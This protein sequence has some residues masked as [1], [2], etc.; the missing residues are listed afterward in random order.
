MRNYLTKY[1]TA[2]LL[3]FVLTQPALAGSST[4][5]VTPGSGATYDVITDGSGNFVGMQGICD[6]SAAAYCATVTSGHLLA[7]QTSIASG[8]VASGAYASGA[9]ASGSIAAGAMVDL[10]TMRGTVGAG[11]APADALIGGAVYNSTPIT[12]SNTQS[13]AL[14]S[15]ANGF[16]KVNVAGGSLAVTGTFYQT[17]QPV[18]IASAQVASGAIAS[19]A[20]ASGSVSSGAFAS[21]SLAAGSMVDL[22]TMR[23][24]IGGTS[25]SPADVL[26]AGCQY[27]A[28][29]PTYTTSDSGAVQC[30]TNGYQIVSVANSSIAVTGTFY[31]ATQPVSIASAQ[32]ASGAYAS[33]SIASGA[34]A[35]GA[36]AS[37]AIVSG[38]D[39]TEGTTADTTVYAGSGGCT[40]VACLKGIYAGVNGSVPAGSALIGS[41]QQY[42]GSGVVSA[43]NGGYTNLLQGNAVIAT[44]NPIFA[45]LTAG[46]AIAGKFGIDQTTPG[47]TNAVQANVASGGIASG[48]Y[49]SGAFA[50]GAAASGSWAD[51]SV[52]TLGAKADAKSTATDTTA[53]TA[54]Q[55]FKEISYMAQNPAGV[56]ATGVSVPANAALGGCV[57]SNA[58]QTAVT[59]GQLTGVEC[60][61]NGKTITLPYAVKE[62]ASRGANSSTSTGTTITLLPASGTSGVY[63]YLTDLECGNTSATNV[64]VTLNDSASSVFMVPATYGGNNKSF[65]IP[66]KGPNNGALTATL[67]TNASTIYCN[68]QGY[69]GQ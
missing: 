43:T 61:L 36:I 52:V 23:A 57:G 29:A 22:L 15:D 60:G 37:G 50:S 33:G 56:G 21:G 51:G 26:V 31:Q 25:S 47:T 13:A 16:L 2:F 6:Q 24:P 65:E 32:V 49:A 41:I 3:G 10:L 68:G 20:Y 54:M 7:T 34:F 67:S 19:G 11:T 8:G 12:V 40:V 64:Y 42:I 55:V 58:D 9:L 62:N 28:S 69:N 48:A 44:G 5:S 17:T 1:L 39:V 59:N 45:Q 35:S 30:T 66:L 18:S 38:G 27:L 63:E 53:I 46:S 14:Q 4:I